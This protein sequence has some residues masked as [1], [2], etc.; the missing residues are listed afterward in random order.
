MRPVWTFAT[1]FG[2]VLAGSASAQAPAGRVENLLRYKPT[3]DGVEYEV[4]TDPAAIAAIKFEIVQNA[5]GKNIGQSLRDGQGQLLLKFVDSNGKLDASGGTHVD[6]WSYYRDGFEIYREVDLDDDGSLDEIRWLNT[7]G[8]RVAKIKDKRVIGW[9][10]ISAEEASK[11]FVQ[12]IVTGKLD[13]IDT[14]I[15]TPAELGSLGLPKATIDRATS[16]LADRK[17][18]VTALTKKLSGS[19]WN[20]NTV[21]QRMD[22]AMPHLIPADTDTSLPADLPVYENVVIFAGLPNGANDANK[23]AYLQAGELVKLGE[24]WKFVSLPKAVDP[25]E[26]VLTSSELRSD[27]YRGMLASNSP[28]ANAPPG[29]ALAQQA[30]ENY[31]K[32]KAPMLGGTKLEVAKYY[33]GRIP[34]IRAIVKAGAGP[35][36][37]LVCNKQIADSLAGAYETDQYPEG[38]KL[39]DAF[40]AEGG[41]IGS[42][43]A[44]RKITAQYQ[45]DNENPAQNFVAVQKTYMDGLKD[46]LKNH[47]K[48]EELA[49]VL[50]TLGSNYEFN[51]QEDDA[52]TYYTQLATGFPDTKQGKRSAGALTRLN[53]VGNEMI[54]YS[55]ASRLSIPPGSKI[56]GQAIGVS[57]RNAV[58]SAG[59]GSR[60]TPTSSRPL[61]RYLA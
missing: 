24:C 53:I 37:I 57:F 48:S 14:V 33:V 41:K 59:S 34:L 21:W 20:A 9:S 4:P 17:N 3:Q 47:P 28:A 27:I 52:K 36:E 2:V 61:S 42:Y 55:T 25:R 43:A 50:L 46:F 5:K 15:A 6:T 40:V 45:L 8:T 44:F 7:S 29:V 38:L 18:Q 22:C 13:L 54:P 58:R 11:V 31:D 56:C 60:L 30:L 10:R 51:A 1:V 12:G 26:P 16:A 35:E 32:E 23:T 49:D 19:G 39:M